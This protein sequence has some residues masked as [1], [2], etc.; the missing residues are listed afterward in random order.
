MRRQENFMQANQTFNGNLHEFFMRYVISSHNVT[1]RLS[2]RTG[3]FLYQTLMRPL[4]QFYGGSGAMNI[5]RGKGQCMRSSGSESYVQEPAEVSKVTDKTTIAFAASRMKVEDTKTAKAVWR[6]AV[7]G[8]A[9]L[10]MVACSVLAAASRCD[11]QTQPQI[12][13]KA[14]PAHEVAQPSS[15]GASLRRRRGGHKNVQL[16][17][18]CSRPGSPAR[19]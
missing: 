2:T 7:I 15:G 11:A 5:D 19:G 12:Q 3:R 6:S 9:F 16:I 4:L 13:A 14:A 18:Q 17:G 10:G 1:R 8:T